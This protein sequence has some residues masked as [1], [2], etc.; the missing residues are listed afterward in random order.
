MTPLQWVFLHRALDFLF[1]GNYRRLMTLQTLQRSCSAYTLILIVVGEVA[2][3]SRKA[4]KREKME[5][6]LAK[7]PIRGVVTRTIW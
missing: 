6:K 3:K 5:E 1:C 2:S 7:E 4:R